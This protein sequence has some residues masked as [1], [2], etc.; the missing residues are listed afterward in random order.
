MDFQTIET[1]LKVATTQNI[2]KTAQQTGYSQSA[3]T[4][5]IQKLEKELGVKLFERIG[6]HVYLTEKGAAF[7]PYANDILKSTN[8]ALA[9][10]Q[11]EEKIKGILRI[12][13]V[14]SICT[15]LLPS[16]LLDFYRVCPEVEV[17]VRSGTTTDL[18]NQ[19]CSHELDFVFTFDEPLY[20]SDLICDV[21]QPEEVIFLTL[22]NE[23]FDQSQC[24][25]IKQLCKQPFLLTEANA[26]Y[27]FVLEKM[28]A[29]KG[30]EIR[31]ILEIGNTETIINLLKKGMGVSF[32][33]LFTVQELLKEKRLM[34]LRTDLK[35][36]K[37][38]H[39]LL[40]HKGKW[41]TPQ[42]EIFTNLVTSY[43]EQKKKCKP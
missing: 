27:R 23:S 22:Y 3:I 35:P 39:Q 40:H 19:L 2:S 16:L 21:K 41:V 10:S 33:P 31:P 6:K 5:Q 28:L 34:Q 24:L 17:I 20:R 30:I 38:Y 14:E 25:P 43:F 1:F 36:T 29:E 37:M 32:L 9:F 7:I 42:M 26:A 12:G 13:G 11:G 4:V 18:I 8:K 15:G